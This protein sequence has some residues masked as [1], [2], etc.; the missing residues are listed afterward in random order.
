MGVELCKECWDMDHMW[1]E[2]KYHVGPKFVH[3]YCEPKVLFLFCKYAQTYEGKHCYMPTSP[4]YWSICYN[5]QGTMGLGSLDSVQQHSFI[6][7]IYS[8]LNLIS[9]NAPPC[10]GGD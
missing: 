8:V 5:F 6:P 10:T 1:A 3:K 4:F 7:T 2:F 9:Q